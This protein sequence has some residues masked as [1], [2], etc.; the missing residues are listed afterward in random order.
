MLNYRAFEWMLK[1]GGIP[2][3]ET[4]GTYMGIDGNCHFNDTDVDIKFA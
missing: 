4:Y 3:D 2:T 1:H